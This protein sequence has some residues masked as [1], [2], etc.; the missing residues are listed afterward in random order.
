MHLGASLGKHSSGVIEIDPGCERVVAAGTPGLAAFR[1]AQAALWNAIRHAGAKKIAISLDQTE[2]R[3]IL[4]ITDDGSGFDVDT[5][6]RDAPPQ[7][8]TGLAGMRHR[9]VSN[10]GTLAIRSRPG[11]GT[12]VTLELPK[13]TITG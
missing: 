13:S 10:G 3:L 9:A 5:V 1:T 6:E 11:E 2:D 7:A 8:F 12:T 4:T